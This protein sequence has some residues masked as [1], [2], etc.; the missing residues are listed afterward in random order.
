[1]IGLL[2]YMRLGDVWSN[3]LKDD[4]LSLV[5]NSCNS[6]LKNED[7]VLEMLGLVANF[8]ASKKTSEIIVNSPILTMLPDLLDE[9]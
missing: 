7:I 2:S 8:C 4:L 1:M 6:Q 3:Y 9:K 5:V